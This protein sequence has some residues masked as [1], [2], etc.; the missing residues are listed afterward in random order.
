MSAYAPVGASP[1]E[2][3][4]AEIMEKITKDI[5]ELK[6]K[7]VPR[8]E[9]SIIAEK[10]KKKTQI[11]QQPL[12]AS[13]EVEQAPPLSSDDM[14]TDNPEEGDS[15]EPLASLQVGPVDL[16]APKEKDTPPEHELQMSATSQ[17]TGEG[18]EPWEKF[19]PSHL[20]ALPRCA[21][22]NPRSSSSQMKEEYPRLPKKPPGV[23]SSVSDVAATEEKSHPELQNSP[24]MAEE[25]LALLNTYR[26]LHRL[27]GKEVKQAPRP[28][29]RSLTPSPREERRSKGLC[30][31]CDEEYVLGHHCS[32]PTGTALLL[33]GPNHE[34]ENLA[35]V[36]GPK[37]EPP[38]LMMA[39]ISLQAYSGTATP[40]RSSREDR[41]VSMPR[42]QPTRG[43]T[44]P[45][46]SH[47]HATPPNTTIAKQC[48]SLPWSKPAPTATRPM[49]PGQSYP[50][51]LQS[52]H[53]RSTVQ[54]PSSSATTGADHEERRT[55]WP[56]TSP[57][58]V[59]Y[60]LTPSLSSQEHEEG[61]LTQ[62]QAR[63]DV[64][65][66]CDAAAASPAPYTA[67]AE[68]KNEN[69]SMGFSSITVEE[70][71][72]FADGCLSE[73]H[74]QRTVEE[75]PEAIPTS[76]HDLLPPRTGINSTKPNSWPIP[77]LAIGVHPDDVRELPLH[78]ASEP[79]RPRPP[80]NAGRPPDASLIPAGIVAEEKKE[81]GASITPS[82]DCPEACRGFLSLISCPPRPRDTP[83]RDGVPPAKLSSAA[84]KEESG[85]LWK[86]EFL[87]NFKNS[88]PAF[89]ELTRGEWIQEKNLRIFEVFENSNLGRFEDDQGRKEIIEIFNPSANQ[90]MLVHITRRT[91]DKLVMGG[92]LN[93]WKFFKISNWRANRGDYLIGLDPVN[94]LSQSWILVGWL[95]QIHVAAPDSYV[96]HCNRSS[97]R[98]CSRSLRLYLVGAV[99]L[100]PDQ[101]FGCR[102]GFLTQLCE[103]KWIQEPI[104]LHH[105]VRPPELE[106]L[107]CRW[108][109][110]PPWP[111]WMIHFRRASLIRA[112]LEDKV[113]GS[114][115][116]C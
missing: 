78:P 4:I 116:V 3:R 46:N 83:A 52:N 112:H 93:F 14:A 108:T 68:E 79:S 113:C 49:L 40:P 7:F 90:G 15:S 76:P 71:P 55:P 95:E 56:Q 16:S 6:T 61:Y 44:S 94:S 91:H 84:G 107:Q 30:S 106:S 54:Q 24:S 111:N 97:F 85:Q 57:R 70:P 1:F 26:P 67:E 102:I 58:R 105:L 86:F 99:S 62:V 63:N 9:A 96:Q 23:A 35:A 69:P 64:L 13:T 66:P 101:N 109:R 43:P 51:M 36:A 2:V 47:W 22:V 37:E 28:P 5:N 75:A 29:G 103:S 110:I 50:P 20:V 81:E 48:Y 100:A 25:F 114:V 38:D 89:L 41:Y 73:D 12:V 104:A 53:S 19:Q 45:S 42:R 21:V 32:R 33:D 98:S 18:E 92:N 34:E 17:M 11:S 82:I 72:T 65:R 27:Q 60:G 80:A 10:E 115:V 77:P 74:L 39:E 87:E 59:I 88:N 31:R 8:I